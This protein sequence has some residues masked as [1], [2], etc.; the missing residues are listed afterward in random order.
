MA[1]FVAG[2]VL[3]AANLNNAINTATVNEQTASAYTLILTDVGK[4]V[5][6]SGS[7]EQTVLIPAES[8]ASFIT[9]SIIGVLANGNASVSIDGAAGVT[10]NSVVGSGSPVALIDQYAAAQLVKVGAD[11]WVAIGGIE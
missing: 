3:S 11:E 7:V 2:E 4:I 8:S 6:M 5:L 9:G 1:Q 10:L